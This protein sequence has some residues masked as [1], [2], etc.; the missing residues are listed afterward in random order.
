MVKIR[1]MLACLSADGLSAPMT[2]EG[3]V[4]GAVFLAYVEQVLTPTLS[5]GEV[6]IMDNL[7][8]HKVKGVAPAIEARGSKIDLLAAIFARFESD[9]KMLVEN[10]DVFESSQSAH[11]SSLRASTQ[12]SLALG[13][14]KRRSRLVCQLRLSRILIP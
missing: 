5:S 4:D 8:A 12:G 6:V 11:S 9:W 10:Q 7:G 1:A 13:D 14:G 2:V 3:A